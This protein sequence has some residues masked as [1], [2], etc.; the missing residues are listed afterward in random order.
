MAI[1]YRLNV[2]NP[3]EAAVSGFEA[4]QGLLGRRQEQEQRLGLIAAQQREAQ[5]RAA[6]VQ[7]KLQQAQ[8]MQTDLAAFAENPNP[9]AK[10]T[11]SL[12]A[13]YPTL[14]EPMK[15]YMAQRSAEEN[16]AAYNEMAAV[17]NPLRIGNVADARRALEIR[18]DAAVNSGDAEKAKLVE[19]EIT[20]LDQSPE[21]VRAQLAIG[22]AHANPEQYK[23]VEEAFE[24]YTGKK[25]ADTEAVR[26]ARAYAETFG[27]PG[28]PEYMQAF[29]TKLNPPPPPGVTVN[30]GPEGRPLTPGQKKVDETF[31]E[32][33]AAFVTGGAT[34]SAKQATQLS[35][36]L[37]Q[38]QQN[39]KLTGPLVGIMPD[40][41]QSFAAPEALAVKQNIQEVVQRN[42][43][44]ILGAQFT[45][46]EGDALIARAFDS[47]LGVSENIKR[48]RRLLDQINTAN[49][50]VQ[51]AVNYYEANGTLQGFKYTVPKISDFQ[52]AVSGKVPK[53]AMGMDFGGM[54]NKTLL[55]Q[56]PMQ[57]TPEQKRLFTEELDK[58]GL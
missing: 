18:R 51:S 43:R 41:L 1:D 39:K 2:I 32:T 6:E 48:V 8:Q 4:G 38:L 22:M 55:Q 34:D 52:D 19:T 37:T 47:S 42:L 56:N 23:K 16:E 11:F 17:Y 24:A 27:K 53:N 9:T 5:M 28:S 33:Y 14:V 3:L 26:T 7:A 45:A 25:E 21:A 50:D 57:M 58:R 20:M 10:D 15:V 40:T 46:K 35:D 54:D 29:R 49:R 44:T 12:I 13:R 30:V 36:A 31:A